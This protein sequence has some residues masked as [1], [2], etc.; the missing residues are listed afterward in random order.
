M[1][2]FVDKGD[3]VITFF[4]LN[5]SMGYPWKVGMVENFDDGIFTLDVPFALCDGA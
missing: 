5:E 2:E 4:S 3:V 1:E